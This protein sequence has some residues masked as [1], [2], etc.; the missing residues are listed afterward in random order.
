M[1]NLIPT[2][3]GWVLMDREMEGEGQGRA[4]RETDGKTREITVFWSQVDT[5][6]QGFVFV[7]VP[8]SSF[9][10]TPREGLRV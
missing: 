4:G 1:F 5:G 2:M 8:F 10:K 7:F 3:E 9:W 6:V